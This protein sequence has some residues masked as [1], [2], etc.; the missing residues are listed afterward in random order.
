MITFYNM[1]YFSRKKLVLKYLSTATRISLNS[2]YYKLI[3]DF[4]GGSYAENQLRNT[5]T[6]SD[7]SV[8]LAGASYSLPGTSTSILQPNLGV[9]ELSTVES[10][11]KSVE[12][13]AAEACAIVELIEGKEPELLER[14]KQLLREQRARRQRK[15]REERELLEAECW[16]SQQGGITA[17]S[18]WLCEHYQR[19]CSVKFP[20][21]MQF[22]SCHHCHNIST[23]CD[24]EEA[25]AC[26]ATHL[27][28]S[29][30]QHEQEVSFY[31]HF[32]LQ[33]LM[34]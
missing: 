14:K 26:H 34:D 5:F 25:K 18:Q 8:V 10:S 3:F 16:Q 17:S 31:S 13:P 1:T 28:C 29:Y 11:D 6:T 21:C 33:E 2:F 30:C 24:N 22:Y 19:H 27:K 9:A 15:E 7:G 32:L 4:L 12:R 23:A 20:C